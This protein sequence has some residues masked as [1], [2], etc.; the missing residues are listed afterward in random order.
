MKR[1]LPLLFFLSGSLLLVFGLGSLG[2]GFWM[3]GD[4]LPDGFAWK[5]TREQVNNRDLTPATVLLPLA[6][7]SGAD[8]LNAALDGG[9]WENALALI[10][11]DTTLSDPT[12]IGALLQLGTRYAVT[13]DKNKAAWCYL[14]AA[15]IAVL[16]PMVT[17]AVREDT[18]L[19]VAAGLRTLGALDA[20]RLVTDQA[21][22]VAQY[23]PALRREQQSRRLGQLANAYSALGAETLASQARNK[24]GEPVAAPSDDAGYL[25]RDPFIV[26]VGNL[27]ES[28]DVNN[29]AETRIAAAKLL[30]GDIQKTPPDRATDWPQDSTAQLRDALL[31]EDRARLAFYDQ[32]MAQVQDPTVRI[33]LLRDEVSWLGVKSRVAHGAFGANLVPDWT[34]NADAITEAWSDAWGALFQLYEAQAN[35]IPNAQAVSQAMEDVTRQELLA[36]RWGWYLRAS[37]KDLHASLKDLTHQLDQASIP[38]LRLDALT[39]GN[40]TTDFLL[41]DELYGKNQQAL[42]R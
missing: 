30:S 12:R 19:Q 9:H 14:D 24:A 1:I 32:Q 38:S 39:I 36:V 37:A 8:A 21:Y 16:S 27:P 35:A 2:A 6:G 42:P 31:Q 3:R 40:Q 29:A 18:F 23:S 34:K 41:P 17:D 28:I 10:A 26:Q 4:A 20:S 15:R 5:P 13:K 25:P 11:Y 33:A 22:L 7:M